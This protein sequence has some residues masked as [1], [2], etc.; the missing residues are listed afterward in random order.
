MRSLRGKIVK[1]RPRLENKK[2]KKDEVKK[3]RLFDER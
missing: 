1:D 3:S 2:T